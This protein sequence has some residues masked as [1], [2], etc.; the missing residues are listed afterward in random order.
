M[1]RLDPTTRMALRAAVAALAAVVLSYL[2]VLER[3]YWTVLTAVVLVSD[4]WGESIQKSL[5]RLAMTVL[6]CLLGWLVYRLCL[7]VPGLRL[8]LLLACI[9]LA[10]YFRPAPPLAGSYPWMIFFITVYVVFLFAVLG[11]W[12]GRLTLVRMEDTAIGCAVGLAVGVLVQPQQA[13]RRLQQELAGFWQ[14]CRQQFDTAY[15]VLLGG[16][17]SRQDLLRSRYELQQRLEALA[18]RYQAALYEGLFQGSLGRS[19]Q[20]FLARVGVFCRYLLGFLDAVAAYPSPGIDL[21]R[22]ELSELRERIDADLDR[23]GAGG[24]PQHGRAPADADA[25]W[26]RTEG[27]VAE[28]LA[29]GRLTR[30]AVLALGPLLSFLHH[31]ETTLDELLRPN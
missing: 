27:K 20:A 7:D 18:A 2:L 23:L 14:A 19:S 3:S 15:A 29:A 30:A 6:G 4:T 10:V 21:L 16:D 31:I 26:R 17:R 25:L 8:A 9:F 5:Q 24:A 22:D 12:S 1:I 11:E 13:G 28:L